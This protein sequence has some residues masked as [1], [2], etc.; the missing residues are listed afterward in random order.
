MRLLTI[1]FLALLFGSILNAQEYLS[2]WP[3]NE[4]PNSKGMELDEI[5]NNERITQVAIPGFY[6]FFP[7]QEENNNSAV[8]ILPSGGY[9]RLT[10]ILCGTQFAKWLNTIGVNAFVLKYR[11]P[12]SPDLLERSIGPLQDAQRAMRLI[13]ANAARWNINPEKIGVMGASA[14][15]HLAST[16]ATY[17]EDISSIGDSLNAL[18]FMPNFMIL[19]SP[20][21]SMGEFTHRGSFENLLG[22]NPSEEL[23]KKYSNELHVNKS[24]PSAFIIHAA[25]D[26]AVNPKNSILFYQ[27]LLDNQILSNLHIFPHG[28][29][30]IGLINNPGSTDLWTELCELWLRELEIIK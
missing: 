17:I 23:I 24:T 2:I 9:H 18:S 11:L 13:R 3:A 15:G 16:L 27:S 7:S 26:N 25:D 29:H 6:T 28:G 19:I 20:V 10:Y 1:L 12:S 21:I 22:Q 14:G 4:M 30:K 8:L 5:E